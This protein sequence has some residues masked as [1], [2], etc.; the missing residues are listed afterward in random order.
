MKG[1]EQLFRSAS[2]GERAGRNVGRVRASCV[3]VYAITYIWPAVLCGA[4][5]LPPKVHAR[6][7]VPQHGTTVDLP[8]PAFSGCT[9]NSSSSSGRRDRSSSS[10]SNSSSN[11]PLTARFLPQSGCPGCR[12][13]RLSRR[14]KV[15][16]ERTLSLLWWVPQ[17]R[18][19]RRGKPREFPFRDK[20]KFQNR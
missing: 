18:R 10:S 4:A 2:R 15:D 3:R 14:Q 12:S 13:T 17:R 8:P 11:V 7:R 16:G 9:S 19:R 20:R 5:P 1:Q 6:I